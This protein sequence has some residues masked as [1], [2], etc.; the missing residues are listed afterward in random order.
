MINGVSIEQKKFVT[1]CRIDNFS[2][3]LKNEIRDRLTAI[4]HGP[5]SVMEKS[6]YTSY[7]NTL[8]EFNKRYITKTENT[9]KGMI[10]EL[11]THILLLKTY[12]R[13]E[14][15]NPFFNMEEGSIKK[16]FDLVIFDSKLNQMWVSEVKSGNA[17]V[18]KA[19]VF[20]KGLLNIAKNDL[21][22]R[23]R[24]NETN[25]WHNAINGAKVAL[26]SGKVKDRINQILEECYQEAV[27]EEQDGLSKNV[28]LISVT[29]KNTGDPI[30]I[31][32][33]KKKR[34]KIINERLFGN[35]IVFSIQKEAYHR[36][37]D[38]LVAEAK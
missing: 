30:N 21:K 20:N 10:G 11:L 34:D 3:E 1:V 32:T 27:D 33:V 5:D 18:K 25:L 29:Y 38:F 16:G 7:K 19:N 35:V 12:P 31:E 8:K 22:N 14:S 4:C 13:F 2:D 26:S 9:K 37:A 15:A 28:I 24:D 36:V 23:L 6:V 17:G